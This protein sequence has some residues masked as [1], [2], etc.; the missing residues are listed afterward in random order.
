MASI[1]FIAWITFLLAMLGWGLYSMFTVFTEGLSVTGMSNSVF[2][3]VWISADITLIA[4]SAGAF[5]M[6]ATVYLMRIERFMPIAKVA[7]L[8]GLAGYISAIM[9][10]IPDIGRPER[11]YFALIY[12]QEHSMLWDIILSISVY[13]TVLVLE[14][15]PVVGETKRIGSIAPLHRLST[16]VHKLMPMFVTVGVVFSLIHQG[17]LGGMY[18][19]L[20]ARPVWFKPEMPVLFVASAMAGGIAM[21]IVASIITSKLSRK[22]FVKSELLS[23]MGKITGFALIAYLVILAWDYYSTR[24]SYFPLRSENLELLATTQHEMLFWGVEIALGGIVP[25]IIL[26]VPRLRKNMKLLFSASGLVILG[27]IVNR[28]NISMVGQLVNDYPPAAMGI[29]GA[30]AGRPELQ[31]ALS[32]YIPTMPEIG[33]LAGMIALGLLIFSLGVKL[34][35]IFE[36]EKK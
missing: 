33:I 17:S 2:W 1:K 9:G 19:V 10:L 18:G 16:S 22:N 20:K 3:G 14:M 11:F 15:V 13:T 27:V 12:W 24:Y 6:S 28:W 29:E 31:L 7:V 35:P 21:I 26:A 5:M 36:E 34:L 8:I 4:L 32:S 23:E 25:A 30:A